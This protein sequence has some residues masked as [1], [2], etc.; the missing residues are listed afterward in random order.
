MQNLHKIGIN[1]R[2]IRLVSNLYLDQSVK[3]RLDQGEARRMKTGWGVR[4]GCCLSQIIFDLY[5]EYFTNE[6]REGF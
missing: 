2:E 1:C 6:A 5:S 4:Q 3:V